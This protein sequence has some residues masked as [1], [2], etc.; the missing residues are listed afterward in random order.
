MDRAFF[1]P[2]LKWYQ[3]L[4][5]PIPGLKCVVRHGDH[6]RELRVG[7]IGADGAFLF[8]NGAVLTDLIDWKLRHR[9]RVKTELNFIFRNRQVHC[10][11]LPVRVLEGNQGAG[12]QFCGMT[13]DTLKEMGDFIEVLRGEGYV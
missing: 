6:E 11:G 1:N 7:R 13:P 10:Q 4:P 8:S 3:G 9:S 2:K 5:K 12:F